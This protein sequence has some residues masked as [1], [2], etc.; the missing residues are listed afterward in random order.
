MSSG[1]SISTWLDRLKASDP[2]AA[3]KIWERYCTR[4]I[5]KAR[6]KL[7]A[8][9]RVAADEEDIA[10]SAFDSFCRGAAR[11]RFPR[12]QDRDDLWQVLVMITDRKVADLAQHE[13]RKKRGSG[14]VHAETDLVSPGLSVSHSPLQNIPDGGTDPAFEAQLSEEIQRLF[15]RLSDDEL[16]S[17]A[18]WKME[19]YTNEEIAEKLGCV[20]RT[21]DRR[22]QVIRSLWAEAASGP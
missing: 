6:S 15:Q 16:R 13:R 2:D 19:G 9:P 14:K 20:C 21:V 17:I 12:L 18:F 10:L 8:I 1:E 7:G 4:L 22:L 5:A 3:Q 11:G